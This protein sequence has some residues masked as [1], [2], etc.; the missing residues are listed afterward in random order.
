MKMIK[1]EIAE[2]PIIYANSRP[3]GRIAVGWGV[4]TTAADEC[5]A[6]GIKKALIV[7]TGLKG[8]GIVAEIDGILKA[9]GVSTEIYDKVTSNPKDVEVMKGYEI[10]KTAG[11]DGVVSVGGGSSHDC[12]KAIRAVACNEGRFIIDFAIYID[13]ILRK[14]KVKSNK[15]TIPQISV[16]TTAGTGAE[17]TLV[18]VITDTTNHKKQGIEMEGAPCTAALIDP[19]LIRLMPRQIAAWTGWDAFTHAF[20]SF[21]S[22]IRSPYTRAI[23][24]GTIQMISENLREFVN[25]RMNQAACETMCWAESMGSIGMNFGGGGGI[26]H[27]LGGGLNNLTDCHHGQANAVVTV[28]AERYNESSCPDRFAE[29]AKAMGVDIR[30]MSRMQAADKW[31]D[32]VERFLS[33][34][35][36][37]TGHLHDRFGIQ[38]ESLEGIASG[39]GKSVGSQGNPRDYN[40]E[41]TMGILESLY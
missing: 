18:A 38:H 15:I 40:F 8:T 2:F 23:Q 10:F 26:V 12:G 13:G 29:M 41:E 1:K 11:C 31:F 22:R 9:G 7:S 35:N 17:S 36:I 28:P 34:L 19:L 25:N 33:D 37:E 21:T 30:G 6:A 5:K 20:E 27:G 16:N 39:Y 24:L 32:E 4:H 14:Q 3:I